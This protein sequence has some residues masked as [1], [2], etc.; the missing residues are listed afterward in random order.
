[1]NSVSFP[2][3]F[4][5]FRVTT[6]TGLLL[7]GLFTLAGCGGGSSGSGPPPPPVAQFSASPTEGVFPL[8]VTFD[9]TSSDSPGSTLVA[10]SWDFGDGNTGSGSTVT[11]DYAEVGE[12][13]V[14]LTVRNARGTEHQVTF[15][16]LIDVHRTIWRYDVDKP[17]YYSAPAVGADGTIYFST[18][19]LIHTSMGRVHAVY[20]D[21]TT[22]WMVDLNDDS[23]PPDGVPRAVNNGASPA[24]GHDGTIFVVDHRNVV[25]AFDSAY[26]ERRWTNDSF[27]SDTPWPVGQK[28]PAIGGDG[29]LYVCA[30][31]NG[32]NTLYALNPVDGQE[33]WRY[34]G[35]RIGN[36]CATSAVVG[37][38]GVVYVASNDWFYAFNSDGTL[39]WPEPFA[40][41]QVSEKTFSSPT[42][43]GDGVIYFGAESAVPNPHGVVYAVNPD[44]TLRWRYVV[45]GERFVRASPAIGPDGRIYV[46][47]RA[48]VNSEGAAQPAWCIA[49]EPDG[50]VAWIF[51]IPTI[52]ETIP[53]DS[54]TSPA[55]GA[56]GVVYFA[57]ETGYIYA[58]N[59]DGS[60]R[61]QERFGNTINWSS[62]AIMPDGTL[63]IGGNRGNDW[64][65]RLVAVQTESF[66]YALS[67]WPKFRRDHANSGATAP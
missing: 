1:M 35:L 7:H 13:T 8:T 43:D 42:I 62:P 52:S 12:Y 66:G 48:Y 60:L 26:G 18:G 15:A 11:H 49:F 39:H 4:R 22:R 63:Y 25:Y 54:Y 5:I 32:E 58:L 53:A 16:N 29:T 56:D 64:G 44:G 51:E 50:S 59:S 41:A 46:T 2:Q 19:I 47:T 3:A 37:A 9:G 28:T 67:P 57:A 34:E 31:H 10:W 45:P 38:G 14:S 23:P 36:V 17:I 33:I 30:G 20:P 6:L 40:L 61:W 65:G 21:G 24:I 27:E 55:I